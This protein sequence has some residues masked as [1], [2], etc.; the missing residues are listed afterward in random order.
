MGAPRS[1]GSH[2]GGRREA[3]G[4][5]ASAET[6]DSRQ[7]PRHMPELICRKTRPAADDRS[8]TVR[9]RHA[10]HSGH[11][12]ALRSDRGVAEK[13]TEDGV[14]DLWSRCG[15]PVEHLPRVSGSRCAAGPWARHR[16]EASAQE[17]VHGP[18]GRVRTSRAGPPP[19]GIVATEPPGPPYRRH[20]RLPGPR[21]DP[22]SPCKRRRPERHRAHGRAHGHIYREHGPASRR[23]RGRNPAIRDETLNGRDAANYAGC[24]RFAHVRAARVS[25]A[26][27]APAVQRS[28]RWLNRTPGEGDPRTPRQDQAGRPA[29]SGITR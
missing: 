7:S 27:A 14:E 23:V 19:A 29:P 8:R 2:A 20:S 6:S 18:R 5:R 3:S 24:T 17:E 4:K 28:P 16:G 22:R 21:A 11:V 13:I 10:G 12:P 9:G 26:C 15:P 25:G 1:A